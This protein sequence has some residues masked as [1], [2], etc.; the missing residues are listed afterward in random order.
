M[1]LHACLLHDSTGTNGNV[2]EAG[3]VAMV[4]KA[5]R[6]R[7]SP[8]PGPAR[9][10]RDL[11]SRRGPHAIVQYGDD[12]ALGLFAGIVELRHRELN[13]VGL[14]LARRQSRR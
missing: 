3:G 9:D 8:A 6:P 14:P 4:L 11:R 12:G 2:A 1:R 10:F 5:D 13:I 7:S